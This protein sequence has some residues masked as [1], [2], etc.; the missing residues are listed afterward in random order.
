MRGFP[1]FLFFS[2]GDKKFQEKEFKKR[3]SIQIAP[4][5]WHS[6]PH[7]PEKSRHFFG[8]LLELSICYAKLGLGYAQSYIGIPSTINTQLKVVLLMSLG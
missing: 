2:F 5:L 3:F 1:T 7:L 4:V 6:V 8:V